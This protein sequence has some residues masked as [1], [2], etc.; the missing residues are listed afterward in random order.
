MSWSLRRDGAF[1][2]AGPVPDVLRDFLDMIAERRG[3][4]VSEYVMSVLITDAELQLDGASDTRSAL[5]GM[6]EAERDEW[7]R[8][9]DPVSAVHPE[10]YWTKGGSE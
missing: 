10:G 4:E 6:G 1:L 9:L 5:H 2:L 3:V 7:R 8:R